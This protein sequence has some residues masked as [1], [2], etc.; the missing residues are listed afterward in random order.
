MVALASDAAMAREAVRVL[1][2]LEG[3]YVAVSEL[4]GFEQEDEEEEDEEE[5]EGNTTDGSWET[6]DDSDFEP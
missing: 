2:D 1:A 4:N 6:D 5:E 3:G